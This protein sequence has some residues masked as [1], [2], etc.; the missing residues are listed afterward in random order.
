MH[1]YDSNSHLGSS[2]GIISAFALRAREQAQ[3]WISCKLLS[4]W[5]LS[6]RTRLAGGAR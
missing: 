3:K 5:F 6:I 4:K 2:S 1:V